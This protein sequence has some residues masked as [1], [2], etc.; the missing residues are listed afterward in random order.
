MNR[1][2]SCKILK[3]HLYFLIKWQTFK[4]DF[5]NKFE[6]LILFHNMKEGKKMLAENI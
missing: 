4:C 5:E 2:F 1:Y 3:K 6:H